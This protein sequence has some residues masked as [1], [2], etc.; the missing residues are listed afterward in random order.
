MRLR[1]I[2]P[3]PQFFFA[4][5]GNDNGERDEEI[6]RQELVNGVVRFKGNKIVERLFK[7]GIIDLNKI[8][9]WDMPAED[10]DQFWQLLGYS[11]SGYGE[12][13]II[14]PETVERADGEADEILKQARG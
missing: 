6:I 12:L 4:F 11:V 9:C 10:V 2:D 7:E 3:A 13:S 1:K 5:P 14:R 8:A